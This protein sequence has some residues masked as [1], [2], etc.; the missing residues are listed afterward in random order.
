MTRKSKNRVLAAVMMGFGGLALIVV[1]KPFLSTHKEHQQQVKED[2][3][4]KQFFAWGE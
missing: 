4:W 3:Q 1:V 2:E